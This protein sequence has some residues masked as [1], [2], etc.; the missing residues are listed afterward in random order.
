MTAFLLQGKDGEYAEV[1]DL[2]KQLSE[3]PEMDT[4]YLQP[5]TLDKLY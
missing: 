4:R 2:F 5:W 1:L 3:I